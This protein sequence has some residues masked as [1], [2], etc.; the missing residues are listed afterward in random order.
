MPEVHRHCPPPREETNLTYTIP[1]WFFD[2]KALAAK[3]GNHELPEQATGAH[4]PVEDVRH[5]RAM[6]Q[7]L[8]I[9]K[10]N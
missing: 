4:H 6:Y 5:K 10:E 9:L 7:Y 3:T 1:T 8:L 2:L